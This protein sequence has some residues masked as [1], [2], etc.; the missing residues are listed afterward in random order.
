MEGMARRI[1]NPYRRSW[2]SAQAV[3]DGSALWA[4]GCDGGFGQV[5]KAQGPKL[6]PG[7]LHSDLL[8][9][10]HLVGAQKPVHDRHRFF[11]AL[12]GHGKHLDLHTA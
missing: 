12:H 5:L 6:A 7:L 8:N 10:E 11:V 3:V 1:L 9:A 4:A 2:G